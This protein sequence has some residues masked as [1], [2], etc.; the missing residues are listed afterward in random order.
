MNNMLERKILGLIRTLGTVTLEELALYTNHHE[1]T[2]KIIVER[3]IKEGR[4]K[5]GR[6]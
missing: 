6:N 4:L 2:I 3:H 5:W 1:L